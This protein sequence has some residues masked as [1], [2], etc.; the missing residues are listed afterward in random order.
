MPTK[1]I[2]LY[3][4]S[5]KPLRVAGIRVELFDAAAGTYVAGDD[6][7]N[8]DPAKPDPQSN[9]WGVDLSFTVST[10]PLDIMIKDPLYRYPGNTVRYLNGELQDLVYLDLVSLPTRAGGQASALQSGDAAEVIGW[11]E[12]GHH[13]E[14][15]DKEAVFNL[16]FNY[17]R[18]VA[19]RPLVV[20]GSAEL[21]DTATNWET[22]LRRVGIDPELFRT[23]PRGPATPRTAPRPNL[24][25]GYSTEQSYG[26]GLEA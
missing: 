22:A 13:W 6:S 9:L 19:A 15:S 3:D 1:M 8:L 10:N 20:A 21:Q 11:I 24:S 18:L 23:K 25:G 2:L 14:D 16:V 4:A 17:I 7:Q 12:Q 26:G 5:N